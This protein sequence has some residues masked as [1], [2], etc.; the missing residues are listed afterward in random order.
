MS[1]HTTAEI[2]D[3]QS[4]PVQK[5]RPVVLSV[6]AIAGIVLSI[7]ALWMRIKGWFVSYG[8]PYKMNLLQ[9]MWYYLG[10]LGEFPVALVM[11]GSSL[12]CLSL[13]PWARR[14]MYVYA[15]GQLALL[16]L[17]WAFVITSVNEREILFQNLRHL[18]GTRMSERVGMA[19]GLLFS[20]HAIATPIVMSMASVKQA[21][22][23]GQR[24]QDAGHKAD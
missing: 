14:G 13:K 17:G 2:L 20:I 18:G 5:F 21:F 24:Y 15:I 8:A 3:Y 11:F 16:V 23:M 12:C 19:L 1:T 4:V 22:Q 9:V 7:I 10:P 6:L